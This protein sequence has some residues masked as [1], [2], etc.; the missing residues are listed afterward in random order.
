MRNNLRG[1]RVGSI[2]LL[3]AVAGMT[4]GSV[5]TLFVVPVFYS[6]IAEQHQPNPAAA[7]SDPAHTPHPAA[8]HWQ[9]AYA[10]G[11]LSSGYI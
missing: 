11:I 1:R 3:L 10:H 2:A 5:F 9:A 4:V 6:L 7:E 8:Q